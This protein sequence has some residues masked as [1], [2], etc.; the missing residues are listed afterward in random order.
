MVLTCRFLRF[1]HLF[2]W[3]YCLYALREKLLD[4][5]KSAASKLLAPVGE[6]IFDRFWC[7]FAKQDTNLA[8]KSTLKDAKM[9]RRRAIRFDSRSAELKRI[10]AFIIDWILSGIPAIIY[11]C[12]FGEI[13]K[14]D[15]L[16]AVN[17]A[18]FILFFLSYPALFVFRDVIFK[19]RSIAKRIL[20]LQ[21]IDA[22]TNVSPSK[23][24]LIIRNLFFF[25]YP[26]EA[27]LL[28]ANNRMLGDTATGTT[29]I[30]KQK[31]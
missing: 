26:I 18:L 23:S 19:G 2:S 5:K 6:C 1:L 20:G 4:S 28:L 7:D 15:G 10:V 25:I 8:R 11:A 24:K 17:A 16:N 9:H 22:Q 31:N 27:I 14:T 30:T 3:T 21:V 13:S 29:V 12:I